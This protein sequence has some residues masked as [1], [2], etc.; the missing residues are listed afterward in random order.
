MIDIKTI[1][2]QNPNILSRRAEDEAVLVMPEQGKVKVLNEVGAAIWELIDGKRDVQKIAEKI[3]SQF[4]V[5]PPTAEKDTL[6]FMAE[7][8]ERE[9][10]TTSAT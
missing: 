8:L 10:I 3:C 7:L 4:D 2:I 1:P 9:I 5:D 6:M